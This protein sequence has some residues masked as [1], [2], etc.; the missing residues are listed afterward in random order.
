MNDNGY[1]NWSDVKET[2]YNQYTNYGEASL[3]VIRHL[4]EP[5]KFFAEEST[6]VNMPIFTGKDPITQERVFLIH[7]LVCAQLQQMLALVTNR[8]GL[9]DPVMPSFQRQNYIELSPCNI[10][11]PQAYKKMEKEVAKM[12][13]GR[14]RL[15]VAKEELK[16]AHALIEAKQYVFVSLDIEAYEED[17]SILLEIGWSIYDSKTDLYM[18]QHYINSSY[19]HL[20]NGKYVDNQKLRFQFGTSVWC[21]LKQALE[22]LRKDL[23]WAVERDGGFVLVGHGLDSD[24]KYLATQKFKWPGRRGGDVD[25][26]RIS[27][28]VAILNTDTMYGASI[29]NPTNPPSLGTT[30]SKVGIDA[31]CLH[32][33]GNDAHYT[34]L[35]F[36]TLINSTRAT[37]G[38]G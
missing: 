24:I 30:L 14:D 37:H 23:D 35:L 6:T 13:K 12:N 20:V 3:N 4:F 26:V 9:P 34:L 11:N 31:W 10:D 22:E 25:N 32:N 33:A 28:A 7:S 1:V 8:R 21:T 15:R 36:M 29:G 27:A 18:D 2:W 16:L 5:E 17:H 38:S 19:R